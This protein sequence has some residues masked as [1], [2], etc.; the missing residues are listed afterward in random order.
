LLLHEKGVEKGSISLIIILSIFF[1]W[2]KLKGNFWRKSP[3][4]RDFGPI[5]AIFR[6][7]WP[8]NTDFYDFW[9]F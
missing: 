2:N 7:F 4:N 5:L 8:K 9:L 3:Q 6:D 1:L